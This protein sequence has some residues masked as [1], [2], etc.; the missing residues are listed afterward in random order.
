MSADLLHGL[1]PVEG[2][3]LTAARALTL[4]SLIAYRYRDAPETTAEGRQAAQDIADA[5]AT[6]AQEWEVLL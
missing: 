3:V 6:L 2:E 1:R 5:I 4:T